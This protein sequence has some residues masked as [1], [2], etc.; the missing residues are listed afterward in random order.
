MRRI[1]RVANFT[2]LARE[3]L[4]EEKAKSEPRT[5]PIP[6]PRPQAPRDETWAIAFKALPPLH[7]HKFECVLQLCLHILWSSMRLAPL[8]DPRDEAG[9]TWLELFVW[10]TLIG[11]R[12]HAAQQADG[13]T[14][15]P[16]FATL[17]R[18]FVVHS[19]RL[20]AF[21]TDET[22]SLTRPSPSRRRPLL[23]IGIDNFLPMVSC[24]MSLEADGS[25]RLHQ[26]FCTLSGSR[27][28]TARDGSIRSHIWEHTG[29]SLRD[30]M[31][32]DRLIVGTLKL[33]KLIPQQWLSDT[34]LMRQASNKVNNHWNSH[35]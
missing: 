7:G 34:F 32:G 28:A 20:L 2:R 4:V 30:Q 25:M 3:K 33:P 16:S 11:G 14:I 18:L 13:F 22:A 17:L 10:F 24:R 15:R 5:I 1:A 12:V 27:K 9:T 31:D 29:G 26:A 21:A 35:S 23:S 19:K 6:P 8:T